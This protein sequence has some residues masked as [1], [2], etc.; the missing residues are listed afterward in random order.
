[1]F[2]RLKTVF[3]TKP[4]KPPVELRHPYLGLLSGEDGL[5]NG[6]VQQDG[7]DIPFV[8]AGTEAE[9]DP[10]LLDRLLKPLDQVQRR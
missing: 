6:R 1:M 8:V 7:R 3:E 4:P 10:N 2:G 5:W 9:P